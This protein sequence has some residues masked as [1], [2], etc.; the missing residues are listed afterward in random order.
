M[1]AE[2]GFTWE[3]EFANVDPRA[4]KSILQTDIEPDFVPSGRLN[5]SRGDRTIVARY[6]VPGFGLKGGS[7]RRDGM[8]FG[9]R[10][11]RDRERLMI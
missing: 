9:P 10:R 3:T 5:L 8:I 7:S 4:M 6:V 11:I 1:A 2:L